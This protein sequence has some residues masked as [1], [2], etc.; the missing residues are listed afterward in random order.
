MIYFILFVCCLRCEVGVWIT[1]CNKNSYTEK[2]GYSTERHR[3][4]C[5]Y[6]HQSHPP[7][8]GTLK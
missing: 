4:C 7:V 1:P 2:N 5:L 8:T 6:T 3:E